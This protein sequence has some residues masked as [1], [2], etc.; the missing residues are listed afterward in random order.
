MRLTRLDQKLVA[1]IVGLFL[2]FLQGVLFIVVG[3]GLLDF[4]KKTQ[5]IA[6]ARRR[7]KGWVPRK[8]MY[9]SR[10]RRAR[11][12]ARIAARRAKVNA[13]IGAKVAGKPLDG[14]EPVD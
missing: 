8:W 14:L 2:P 10:E 12:V 13:K 5:V 9:P 11:R 6:R 3:I 1:G 4:E 7:L